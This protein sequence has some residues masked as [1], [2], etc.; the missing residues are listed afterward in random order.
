MKLRTYS[1]VFCCSLWILILSEVTSGVEP[2]FRVGFAQKDVTP[3]VPTPMW[4]YGA[5]K[6][7]LSEGILDPLMVKAIIIEAG[8][9]RVALVGLDMGRAPTTAMMEH[10]RTRIRD[11]SQVNHVLIVGSHT[12]H[13]PVF[14]LSDRDGFGKGRFDAAIGYLRTLPDLLADTIIEAAA[15]LQPAKIGITTA[16]V[17]YNR[18]RHTKRQPPARDPQLAV[19]R[20]DDL[21]GKPLAILVNFAGHPVMTE[22]KLLRFSADYP[23]FLMNTVEKQLGA[24]CVFMQGASGDLSVNPIG[25]S[26][27]QQFGELLG[28]E[29]VKLAS[30]IQ[31]EA[32]TN[33]SLKGRV[34]RF[35]F[36]KR[37]DLS[38]PAVMFAY[39]QAFFPEL[40]QN[41]VEEYRDGIRPELNTILLNRE[42][43]IVGGS[44]EF[45]CNHAVRLR[46]RSYVKHT[47]FFGCC[48]GYMNYFPTIEAASEGGY[49]ADVYVSPVEVGAGE[50]MINRALTNIYVMLGR[51][52]EGKTQTVVPEE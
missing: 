17:P 23:G 2:V 43:A 52:A 21:Q 7:K 44:G 14:E 26:G 9:E 24:P 8:T 41:F 15:G 42:I 50:Q 32:P 36:T 34:D 38:N 40:I 48:N 31:T 37:I 12:H 5:R 3:Q 6:D 20:F 45:F 1:A 18:N 51:I 30:T 46:E 4:G 35:Q 25:V 10:I 28:N 11:T 33:P 27:P 13:G 49:G 47:L 19:M 29:C 39:S 16:D 22:S